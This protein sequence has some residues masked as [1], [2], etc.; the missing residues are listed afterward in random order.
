MDN[1][2]VKYDQFNRVDVDY[3]IEL[4]R[5]ERAAYVAQLFRN[6]FFKKSEKGAKT[7]VAYNIQQSPA[8]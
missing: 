1:F 7:R 2:E 8:V 4:A 5:K 6:V 3:Y